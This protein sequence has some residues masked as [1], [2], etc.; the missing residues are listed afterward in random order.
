M[1]KILV[2]TYKILTLSQEQ[3]TMKVIRG[4]YEGVTTPELDKLAAETAA[5]MTTT[6]PDYAVLAARIEISNMHKETVKQ[7]SS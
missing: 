4:L 2:I 1:L 5:Q 6:H 3:I 7:F